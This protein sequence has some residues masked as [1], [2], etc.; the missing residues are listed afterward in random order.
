MVVKKTLLQ[1]FYELAVG[2]QSYTIDS[3]VTNRQ[4]DWL[5]ISLVYDKSN[6]HGTMYDSYNLERA[7]IFIANVKIENVSNTYS[8]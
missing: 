6:K 5:E 7:Y 1:K 3:V 8:R 4:F 2:A